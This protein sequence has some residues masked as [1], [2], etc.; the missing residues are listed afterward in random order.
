L[1]VF[2]KATTI[3][4]TYWYTHFLIGDVQREI[5]LLEPAIKA[6]RS[7]L[8]DR[9]NDM[10]VRVVL[11]ETTLSRGQEEFQNGY[12][13]RAEES[14]LEALQEATRIISSDSGTRMAWKV[15]ADALIGLGSMVDLES[16]EVARSLA[17]QLLSILEGQQIDEKIKGMNVV[18]TISVQAL[19]E[20]DSP[21]PTIL[22]AVSTLACKM[23]VLLETQNE[24][25]IGS[26][27]LDLGI[28]ISVF[29]KQ[30][31]TKKSATTAEEALDQA[32]RCLKF[33]LHKEPMNSIFW[34][35]LG[36][37]SFDLSPR[38][39]QHSFIKSI[40]YNSRSAVPW[41]N[42]GIFYLVHGDHD[43]AN[44]ALLK[45]QVIDPDWSAA[46]I[47]QASLAAS[48]GHVNESA[49]LF[50]HA[51]TL[52]GH[53][54]EA[55]LGFATSA[56]ARYRAAAFSSSNDPTSK[57]STEILSA[58][59]F[60][61]S[62]YLALRPNDVSALHLNAL[63]LEQ[64]GDLPTAC[65]SLEKAATLLEELYEVD[66]SAMVEAQFVIAQT[67]L[68]RVR[69]ASLDYVG[70]LSAFEAALSLLSTDERDTSGETGV[71]DGL[72]RSESI[73]LLTECRLGSGIAHHLLDPDSDNAIEALQRGLED[74]EGVG[75][76]KRAEI[77]IA[78][79]RIHWSRDQEH[80]TAIACFLDTP[81]VF[82]SSLS[83]ASYIVI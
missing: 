26:A 68:G 1:K 16:I 74:I 23:R 12:Y 44:Q 70:A 83:H 14:Y 80:E 3:D 17:S 73:L 15:A 4:S 5:G 75:G 20:S 69:L 57:P 59:I 11:A 38:L 65:E 66:E 32:I 10:G 19:L 77:D 55:D 34:N 67:N 45:A 78:L 21:S 2:A 76:S 6:F 22:S 36:V 60:A 47:G 7:I 8:L 46:W 27:W 30:L 72:S 24:A 54:P 39:A 56:F 64:V 79:G 53:L 40:E 42:L 43:L 61:L 50:E 81:D 48:A 35:A 82:V 25:A 71:A 37:L 18:T 51:F 62:R 31:L 63:L 29:R 9:P 41:T 28:S 52:P 49:T 13:A 58:P 33:A